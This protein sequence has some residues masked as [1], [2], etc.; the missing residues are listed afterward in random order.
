[1]STNPVQL[2]T[3]SISA[4]ASTYLDALRAIAA[5]LVVV[6]HVLL[7]YFPN[8]YV[9]RGGS[10]GVVIFFL[11]SGFLIT[12]SMLNR[13]ASPGPGLPAFLADRMAR[14]MTPFVPVLILVVLLNAAFI[15]SHFG[16]AGLNRG[17]AAFVGN[18]LMLHDHPFFQALD[19]A[20]VDTWWR[21]RPYNTAEP[22]WT[23][24]V[25]FWLY[26][27]VGLGFF[28]VLRGEQIRRSYLWGLTI[29]SLPVL[30]WNCV[31]G[32]GEALTLVWMVGAIAAYLLARLAAAD[33]KV[34]WRLLAAC[35]IGCG[36]LA[37]AARIKT[38]GFEP[39]D[40]QI[41]VLIGIVMFG[42]L[43][44][45]NRVERVSRWVATPGNFF[46]SY[47]YS[48]YLT[49]NTILVLMFQ[50]TRSLPKPLSIVIGVLT[51]QFLAWAV[52]MAFERHYRSVGR[53]LRPIFSRL[54]SPR[55]D[56]RVLQPA[57]PLQWSHRLRAP[58]RRV[59]RSGAG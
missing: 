44:A 49:H 25:E 11:L 12:Q 35:L 27:A 15:E 46:A 41:A 26:A 13:A 30:V 29:V 38:S 53:W 33:A 1:M 9:Y 23:V 14:I 39:Y 55:S 45:L 7:L 24:A 3:A 21:I 4:P 5:N 16:G 22:F 52:Y 50:Y 51:A 2:P 6:A 37:L 36:A 20:H 31:A 56:G 47:S 28:C 8:Q 40:L 43:I 18:F 42:V 32:G 10:L 58:F 17:L 48:L 19:I 34:H 54:M 59:S 57:V